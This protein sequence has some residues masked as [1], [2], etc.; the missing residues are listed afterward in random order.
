MSLPRLGQYQLALQHPA[1]AFADAEL[2]SATVETTPMG[3]PRVISGG[4]ALTYHLKNGRKEWAVRCFHREASELGRRYQAIGRMIAAAPPGPFVTAEFLDH[5]V[6]VEGE[7]FPVT[8]MPWLQ[9]VPLN[10]Y[11]ETNLEGRP[12]ARLAQRFRALVDRLDADGVAHGDLQHGNILVDVFGNLKL[13]DYDGMFVPALAGLTSNESGHVNYQHPER[14]GQFDRLLDRFSAAVIYTAL[15]ALAADPALWPRYSNGENLLFKRAD[16]DLPHASPLFAELQAISAVAP[17]V[18]RLAELCRTEYLSLPTLRQFIDG[19]ARVSATLLRGAS[20]AATAVQASIVRSQFE[21][22]D[23]ADTE[24]LLHHEGDVVTVVGQIAATRQR[25]SRQ[26]RPYVVV[27]LGPDKANGLTLE[28]WSQAL[29]FFM[30]AGQVITAYTGRW[31]RATGLIAI[32]H[33]RDAARTPRPQMVINLPS[34]VQLLSDDDAATLLAAGDTVPW[35][36]ANRRKRPP[37][38]PPVSAEA[39]TALNRLYNRPAPANRVPP[40]PKSPRKRVRSTKP[41]TQPRAR[42]R[43]GKPKPVSNPPKWWRGFLDPTPSTSLL[44]VGRHAV[45]NLVK[46]TLALSA[47]AAL[48]TVLLLRLGWW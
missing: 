26:K 3:L 15:S 10:R 34:D 8:K 48:T 25:W 19:P 33:R 13:V 40:K 12:L 28:L 4:F 32:T 21:V 43:G 6:L 37:S 2:K 23:A 44:S 1:T 39:A 38:H 45:Q 7:W 31:V 35:Y 14:G 18:E 16:F 29:N 5:G 46:L 22:I 47:L 24:R 36:R 11:V 27:N 20:I 9:A 17:M 30:P 42:P 41:A